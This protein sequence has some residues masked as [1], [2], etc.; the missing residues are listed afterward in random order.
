MRVNPRGRCRVKDQVD[1]PDAVKSVQFWTTAD[2]ATLTRRYWNTSPADP[3]CV[4]D[5]ATGASAVDMLTGYTGDPASLIVISEGN[6]VCSPGRT[7]DGVHRYAVPR[8]AVHRS[9]THCRTAFVL[10]RARTPYPLC[11]TT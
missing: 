8:C 9:R 2:V 4:P 7:P 6:V 5:S 3:L 10:S 1:A 11:M